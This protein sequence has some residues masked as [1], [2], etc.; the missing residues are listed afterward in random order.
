MNNIMCEDD[1]LIVRWKSI[2]NKES[3]DSEEEETS[4]RE[5]THELLTTNNDNDNDN[6]NKEW[7]LTLFNAVFTKEN[8]WYNNVFDDSVKVLLCTKVLKLELED[9]EI[10]DYLNQLTLLQNFS[11]T[12]FYTILCRNNSFVNY[13]NQDPDG[14]FMKSLQYCVNHIILSNPDAESSFNYYSV[15]SAFELRLQSPV[16]SI[17][18]PMLLE[19]FEQSTEDNNNAICSGLKLISMCHAMLN[20][21]LFKFQLMLALLR[22]PQVEV[23]VWCCHVLSHFV[24][25]L[26]CI[27][28]DVDTD[29]IELFSELC[30]CSE[31]ILEEVSSAG[32]NALS[33]LLRITQNT[34]QNLLLVEYKNQDSILSKINQIISKAITRGPAFYQSNQQL[35]ILIKEFVLLC[36]GNV[37]ARVLEDVILPLL[38]NTKIKECFGDILVQIIDSF[39]RNSALIPSQSFNIGI[40]FC[41]DHLLKQIDYLNE[42]DM[43]EIEATLRVIISYNA[44]KCL[45]YLQSQKLHYLCDI[46]LTREDVIFP[47]NV[48]SLFY[49]LIHK[50]I[51]IEQW[52]TILMRE[53]ETLCEFTIRFI[54]SVASDLNDSDISKDSHTFGCLNFT[55]SLALFLARIIKHLS[56]LDKQQIANQV[57]ISTVYQLV[58]QRDYNAILLTQLYHLDRDNQRRNVIFSIDKIVMKLNM[59]EYLSKDEK[60]Y[61]CYLFL[62]ML[63]DLK[64]VN[65]LQVIDGDTFSDIASRIVKLE[66]NGYDVQSMTAILERLRS[67]KNGRN[68]LI[69]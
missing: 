11:S 51:N 50:I 36:I 66:R 44:V 15:I 52:E 59:N 69:Q 6:E 18:V 21:K 54:C 25:I 47:T 8:S 62:E 16:H 34:H 53:N 38:T 29:A 10:E 26:D 2:L 58:Q 67:T 43:N 64:N 1:E 65:N 27:L 41:L 7:T 9:I 32:L 12:Y 63:M 49:E 37:P 56:Q 3:I 22:K 30:S 46:F 5:E 4:I 55:R 23:K 39:N 24:E 35:I 60:Y 48:L 13:C 19:I 61:S 33:T 20:R 40:S 31:S 17:V 57:S 14:L 45:C 28:N 42:E 68:T